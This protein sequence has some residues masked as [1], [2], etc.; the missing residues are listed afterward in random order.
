MSQH[1]AFENDP[2]CTR[3]VWVT[4]R[5]FTVQNNQRDNITLCSL[6]AVFFWAP[7]LIGNPYGYIRS[8]KHRILRKIIMALWNTELSCGSRCKYGGR[9]LYS[10]PAGVS[11]GAT[12]ALKKEKFREGIYHVL[13][14]GRLQTF[15]YQKQSYE[16]TNWLISFSLFLSTRGC[17]KFQSLCLTKTCFYYFVGVLST[18]FFPSSGMDK[19]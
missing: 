18:H 11:L 15:S 3:F 12:L 2:N 10:V 1:V 13:H 6:V 14:A 9:G 8:E 17:Y 19:T 16:A 7:I 5:Q 4:N